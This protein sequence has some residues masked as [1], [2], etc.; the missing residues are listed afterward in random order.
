MPKFTNS[1]AGQAANR[2]WARFSPFGVLYKEWGEE[3]ELFAQAAWEMDFL[4]VSFYP[5]AVR[6]GE[7]KAE[8]YC[9]LGYV[10]L[11]SPVLKLLGSVQQ[12]PGG[13]FW[14]L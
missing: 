1:P 9:G 3:K 2:A 6:K 10:G 13:I 4:F 14:P 11:E 5:L 8:L 7:N 12:W